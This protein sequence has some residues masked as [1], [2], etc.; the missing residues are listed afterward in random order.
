MPKFFNFL[1]KKVLTYKKYD[2]TIITEVE[3]KQS[4]KGEVKMNRISTQEYESKK[5]AF[6]RKHELD[7]VTTSPMNE[8]GQYMKHYI[9]TDNAIWY[10]V[11]EPEY[12]TATAEVEVKGIKTVISQEIKLFRTEG[13]SSDDA[14]S[15]VCYEVF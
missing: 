11:N 4:P 8:Y 9:C 2:S 14:T 6:L 10:E 13:W 1:S 5:Q 12:T 15:I 7:T 3:N